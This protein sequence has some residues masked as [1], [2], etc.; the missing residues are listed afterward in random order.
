MVLVLTQT[1]EAGTEECN[2]DPGKGRTDT[3]GCDFSW[4]TQAL[5]HFFVSCVSNSNIIVSTDLGKV[6]KEWG[7]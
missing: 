5:L 2:P 4:V 7:E 6:E 1:V 3:E